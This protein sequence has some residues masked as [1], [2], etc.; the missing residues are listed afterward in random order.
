[1]SA[2]CSLFHGSMSVLFQKED[3]IFIDVMASDIAFN[4]KPFHL[5]LQ[6][7]LVDTLVRDLVLNNV[8]S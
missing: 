7:N 1:M 3:S 6:S 2:W 5:V 4:L 8:H